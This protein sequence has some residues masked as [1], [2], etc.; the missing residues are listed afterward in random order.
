MVVSENWEK[1][2]LNIEQGGW[3]LWQHH[4]GL[5]NNNSDFGPLPI[6]CNI[7]VR[8]NFVFWVCSSFTDKDPECTECKKADEAIAKAQEK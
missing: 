6:D 2:K 5:N 1:K 3:K 4:A 7:I 8:Q